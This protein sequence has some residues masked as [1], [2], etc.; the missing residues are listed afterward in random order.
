MSNLKIAIRV[1]SSLEMGSGHVMRCISL[2]DELKK[3]GGECIFITRPQTG[4]L[5]LLLR[6]KGY[7]VHLLPQHN[8]NLTSISTEESSLDHADWLGCSWELDAKQTLCALTEIKPDWL[9]IDHYALDANWEVAV[10]P[11]DI[12]VMVVDDLADRPH[13]CQLLLDQNL[14][15]KTEDYKA[16]VPNYCKCLVGPEYAILRPEFAELREYSLARR[17]NPI[18]KKI[19]VSMGGIDKDNI[20]ETVLEILNSSDLP[21]DCSIDVVMGFHA[22]WLEQVKNRAKKMKYTTKVLVNIADM[23]RRMAEADLS[24]GAAGGT[25]WE[26]STLGLPSFLMVLAE[27]QRTNA[28]N[29][30][31]FGAARDF[32]AITFSLFLKDNHRLNLQHMSV[33]ASALC[34]GNGARRVAETLLIGE[35]DNQVSLIPATLS[36][37]D[38][39]YSL[40]IQPEVRF[41]FR[42][43]D[44]PDYDQHC[45]WYEKKLSEINGV[46]FKIKFSGID[47]GFVRVDNLV[48]DISELSII[49]SSKYEGKGIGTRAVRL[50]CSL[51]PNRELNAIVHS[52]NTGSLKLFNRAGFTKKSEDGKFAV[53][54]YSSS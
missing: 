22:P 3:N 48:S 27:N 8:T 25:S 7:K 39:I 41:F 42:N 10:N 46:I 11:G 26:R 20:T 38:Y 5:S 51:L 52:E 43:I 4:D 30:K 13:E 40:Q 16:L 2:A 17:S 36:D 33:V 19:F 31:Q 34:Q 47:T 29:L 21:K 50:A 44:V 54:A 15:R 12:K 35:E 37:C 6:M 23:A 9:I 1:D 24:V 45:L 32:S 49:I 53:L 28:D 18:L 14:G